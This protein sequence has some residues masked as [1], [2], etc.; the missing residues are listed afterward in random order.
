MERWAG[1]PLNVTGVPMGAVSIRFGCDDD[2]TCSYPSD[3]IQKG[4]VLVLHDAEMVEEGTGFGVPLLKIGPETIFPGYAHVTQAREQE[5]VRVNY[6]LNLVQRMVRRN[7]RKMSWPVFYRAQGWFSNVHRSYPLL[8]GL[9]SQSSRI[10]T[11][12]LGLETLFEEVATFS[13]VAV[14]YSICRESSK[15]RVSVDLS[16]LPRNDRMEVIIANEQGARY[17]DAYHDS[18]GDSRNG[19]AIGTW[20]EVFADEA[21]LMD[22]DSGIT[23]SLQRLPNV[24]LF[25]GRELVEGSL[26][27]SGLNYVLSPHPPNFI[28][29]IKIGETAERTRKSG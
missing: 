25:R 28:Y 12:A 21:S 27:W 5:M 1:I 13:T 26:A 3:R 24:R 29:D 7:G 11:K 22:Q 20:N 15:V 16:E 18:F 10:L 19:K 4:L 14:T 6:H 2:R 17:F 8:R 23:F 9:I